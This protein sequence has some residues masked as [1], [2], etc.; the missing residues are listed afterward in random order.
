MKKMLMVASVAS[1]IDQF[2]MNNIYV[3]QEMGYEI[4]VAANFQDGNTSSKDR[5]E[6]F[7]KKLCHLGIT[8]YQIDFSRNVLNFKSNIDAYKQL[9]KIIDNNNYDF[10]HSHSPI[11][12][13]ISRIISGKKNIQAIYTA[14]GFH[15]YKNAP[16]LNWLIYYP[17]E[18]LLSRYTTVLIT[19]NNEDF[20]RATKMNASE[21]ILCPG[22][23]LNTENFER[24][25]VARVKKREELNIDKDT[26]VILSIGEL[27]KRKNHESALK[28][29]SKIKNENFVYI[30]CGK[31][32]LEEKLKKISKSLQ[33]DHKVKFLGFR[34]D[35][36]DICSA[37][38]IFVFPSLQEGLP[39]SVMEA[40]ASEL[41]IVCS[42]IRGHVDLITENQ[43]GYLVSTD[44]A[45][46]FSNAILE[47]MENKDKRIKFG[48]YNKKTI[49]EY[50]SSNVNTILTKIYSSM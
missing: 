45:D 48:L 43:G 3:L 12:G 19:I 46:S 10:I 39:V 41:P 24:N 16:L 15:F 35:I 42:N 36:A 29:L 31:G 27:I 30:I 7:K 5:V 37:S 11:G 2:T 22:I 17:I 47:L 50:D 28:A 32:P 1:M 18:W 20:M 21:V 49:K 13:A 6:I 33:I 14:H 44:E 8:I 9:K 38:D 23:G 40:M 34:T 25:L 26:T 4:E